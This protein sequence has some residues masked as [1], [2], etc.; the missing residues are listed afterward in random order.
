[1]TASFNSTQHSIR[2]NLRA[3]F[4]DGIAFS[5]MAGAGEAYFAAFVLALG[6]AKVAAGLIAAVPLLAGAV[7]QMISPLAVSRLSSHRRWV[8]LCAVAQ[9]LS[10]VPLVAAALIGEAPTWAVF[11]VAAIYWGTGMATG[12]AWNTWVDTLV[13]QRLR[14]SYFSRRS[15]AAQIALLAAFFGSGLILEAGHQLDKTLLAFALLFIIAGSCRGLSAAFLASQSEPIPLPQGHRVVGFRELL[16]RLHYKGDLRLLLYMLAV[17]LVVQISGPYFTPYM[18]GVLKMSY[19]QYSILVATALLAKIIVLTAVGRVAGRIGSRRLLWIGGLGLV[20][21]S[22]LWLISDSFPHLLFVQTAAGGMWALYE[23]ATF[24]LLFE[25]IPAN[26]RTSVL[27]TYNLLS[28]LATLT[29]ALVGGWILHHFEESREAFHM[30]FVVSTLVRL[31]TIPL[32]ARVHPVKFRP[33][34]LAMRMIAV[35]PQL[36]SIDRPIVPSMNE[37]AAQARNQPANAASESSHAELEP[38]GVRT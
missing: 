28:A 26:Q 38:T 25:T 23:L 24:L 19:W 13:P 6:K 10:F 14:T 15:R 34:A 11:V 22:G 8:I 36:G 4:G 37:P 9:A 31:L 3:I 1:M 29:G 12:P 30:V 32:L 20:P 17:S 21:L 18:L 16:A 35:R 2:S 5:I 7:L 33:V 27:T